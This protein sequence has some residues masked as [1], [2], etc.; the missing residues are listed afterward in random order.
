MPS[1]F[2]Y[3]YITGGG[4]YSARAPDTPP[5]S[6]LREGAAMI[7]ALA[8]D[9]SRI[10]G[11]KVL[12]LRDV[13]LP[14][15]RFPSADI[16][17]VADAQ[18]ER[19]AFHDLSKRADWTVL[20]APEFDGVLLDR[21]R[22]AESAGARLLSPPSAFVEVASEKNQTADQLRQ[23][24]IPVPAAV[25]LIRGTQLPTNFSYPA[26]VKP[27]DGAGSVGVQSV[28]DQTAGYEVAF[29][30]EIARLEEFRHGMPA[31]VAILCG[32]RDKVALP[33]CSQRISDD[34]RFR[35]MGGKTPL[36]ESLSLRAKRLGLAAVEALP[37]A[38]GYVG[39]DL[40]LGDDPDG[41]DDV[42]I[43]VNPRLT[44]SYVGLRQL[45]QTNL[46]AAMM[47]IAQGHAAELSFAERPVEFDADGRVRV[48]ER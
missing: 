14:D 27:C 25:P 16:L 15:L 8:D 17:E 35:Y 30:G 41:R 1:V 10:P 22:W 2:L 13:R 19:Q 39:V 44:T 3:E 6:L 42:V 28:T 26:V 21:C 18:S 23:H 29:D 31:S 20:I 5:G 9:F 34:G 45:C 33:P 24:G 7:G 46:A 38:V 47:T 40:I 12:L 43:E 36:D 48:G 11:M 4:T 32:P 37:P